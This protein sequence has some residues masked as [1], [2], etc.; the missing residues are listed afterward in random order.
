MRRKHRRIISTLLIALLLNAQLSTAAWAG[1]IAQIDHILSGKEDG[2]RK[3]GYA[4]PSDADRVEEEPNTEKIILQWEFVDDDNLSGEQLSLIGVSQENRADFDTVVSMLPGKVRVEI[5]ENDQSYEETMAI[6]GWSCPEYEQDEEGLWPYTGEYEFTAG[7][8]EGYVCEPPVSVTVILGGAA[9]YTINDRFTVEGL[10]YKELGPDTVQLMGYDGEKPEGTLIIPDT[11]IKP[12][13]G[14]EY[15]VIRI[16]E[17]AFEDCAGL[18]GDLIIPDTVIEIGENAFLGCNYTGSLILPDSLIKIGTGAF[19]ESGFTGEL[20]LP[21]KLTHIGTAAFF[22]T[23]FTGRLI[24]P[25]ELTYIG[26]RAFFECR[27]TGDLLIP[28]SVRHL[29]QGAFNNTKFTGKLT[30]SKGLTEI[31]RETFIS[32]GFTGK[33]TIPDTITRIDSNAFQNCNFT[34]ELV[35]PDGITSIGEFAFNGCIGLKGRLRIPDGLTEC[36]ER[37]F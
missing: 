13:N 26:S 4:T 1:S 11:V 35:L 37:A 7:L 21:E 9:A 10:S 18:T 8:P 25:E 6:T 34:G 31:E 14:R 28:D 30:L 19:Y 3:V 27:F 29:A 12:A 15:K 23:G 5:D 32:C 20:H 24:L 33:L 17:N 22:K 16:G 2:G 36:G